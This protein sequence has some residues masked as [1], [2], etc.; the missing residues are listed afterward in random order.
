MRA[1]TK[2]RKPR[3]LLASLSNREKDVSVVLDLANEALDEMPLSVQ[4]LIV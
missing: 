1:P 4:I 2:C 3:Y